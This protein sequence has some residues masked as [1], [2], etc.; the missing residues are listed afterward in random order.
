MNQWHIVSPFEIASNLWDKLGG[1]PTNDD[2]DI[3]EEFKIP[4]YNTYFEE[5]TNNHTIW[6]WFEETFSLSVAEDLMYTENRDDEETTDDELYP[7]LLSSHLSGGDAAIEN[8]ILLMGKWHYDNSTSIETA[9]GKELGHE[10]IFTRF[11]NVSIEIE[12][13]HPEGSY[14]IELDV[15]FLNP[16]MI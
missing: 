12:I 1:I 16:Q 4:I 9:I 2:G 11:G 14:E 13:L 10:V 7:V 8:P 6:H 5:G 15:H 3:E